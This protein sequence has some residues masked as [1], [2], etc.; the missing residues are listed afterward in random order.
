LKPVD[1][2]KQ[3]SGEVRSLSLFCRGRCFRRM[4]H[5]RF[6]SGRC[7]FKRLFPAGEKRRARGVVFQVAD[8]GQIAKHEFVEFKLAL[9]GVDD[10][11]FAFIEEQAVVA[12]SFLSDLVS[13]RPF[14]PDVDFFEN[15]VLLQ[16]L[17]NLGLL[18][19]EHLV[20]LRSV[21]ND[22]R[23]VGS[24]HYGTSSGRVSALTPCRR[25]RAGL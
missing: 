15:S 8:D 18:F 20:G 2:K 10:A 21:K 24:F 17:L 6:C 12:E 9:N 13:E 16:E 1:V 5:R 4:R 3:L 22:N 19:A 25:V 23:F 7:F 14:S 11:A